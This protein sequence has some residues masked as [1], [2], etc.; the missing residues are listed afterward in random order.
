ME[1]SMVDQDGD[2]RSGPAQVD[3]ISGPT[4]WA[5][6]G[7]LVVCFVVIPA[8]IIVWP[9]T[10]VPYRDA[11]LALSLVPGI[12]LGAVAVWLGLRYGR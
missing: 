1:R 8:A 5:I 3:G 12:A 10:F 6:L 9:P 7:L 4:G 11:Y 2:V